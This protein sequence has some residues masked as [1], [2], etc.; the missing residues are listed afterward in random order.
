MSKPQKAE[1]GKVTLRIRVKQ[2]E[3]GEDCVTEMI[4][5]ARLSEKNGKVYLIYRESNPEE[6]EMA[7][8]IKAGRDRLDIVRRGSGESHMVLA[9][10]MRTAEM[11][12]TPAGPMLIE[13]ETT[14]YRLEQEEGMLRIEAEYDLFLEREFTSSCRALIEAVCEDEDSKGVQ[15]G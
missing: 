4:T 2:H 10:G 5:S 6:G 1:G 8:V 9:V 12:L 15:A 11:R 7:C 14:G 13:T 3:L